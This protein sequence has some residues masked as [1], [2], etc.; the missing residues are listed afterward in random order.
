MSHSKNSGSQLFVTKSDTMK[1]ISTFLFSM[2]LTTMVTGNTPLFHIECPDDVTVDCN[3][4]L[5][6]LS[7]YGNAY[8]YG[9]GDPIPAGDPEVN[10]YL[11]SCNVGSIT[12]TWTESDYSGNTYTC[13]Q[14]ITVTS[15]ADYN[16]LNIEWPHDYQTAEC[17]A[18]LHPDNLAPP[19]DYPTWDQL[20]CAM[21]MQNYK[22]EV[23]EVDEGCVKILRKWTLLDWC[24]Y[25]PN[26]PYSKG[27]WKH[28]QILKIM[29]TE[30]PE[31]ECI[32][33]LTVSAGS[34][35]NSTYV[36]LEKVTAFNNCG[37]NISV[38]NNSPYADE[39]GAD[40]S[41]FY[42][43]G[44]TMIKYTARD[45]CG[46]EAVCK[47]QLTVVDE[48]HPVPI[49]I[50]GISASLG[51]ERDGYYVKIFPELFNKGSYDNCT[52]KHKLKLEVEPD[53]LTCDN[54]DTTPV[55][56]IVTDENGNSD[57]CVTYVYLT[58]NQGKCPPPGT[59]TLAGAV[60]DIKGTVVDEAE[61]GLKTGNSVENVLS[62]SN[63]NYLFD[64]LK[65]NRDYEIVLEADGDPM[66]GWTTLDQ[67]YIHGVL[68]RDIDLD[69]TAG[70]VS[71]DINMDGSITAY[72][73]WLHK[74]YML[75][76]MTLDS[77]W[78]DWRLLNADITA[79]KEFEVNPD[80]FDLSVRNTVRDTLIEK[81]VLLL[82]MGDVDGSAIGQ[83]SGRNADPVMLASETESLSPDEINT[84]RLTLEE[85]V[86]MLGYQYTLSY[87][88]NL[89]KSVNINY[90]D[91]KQLNE[92]DFGFAKEEDG[93]ILCS[94]IGEDVLQFEES[95][96]FL[97]L[98]VEVYE[99]TSLAEAID[100]NSEYLA[101][102]VYDGNYSMRPLLLSLKST[103]A[104]RSANLNVNMKVYPNPVTDNSS[105]H[106][107]LPADIDPD[108]CRIVCIGID[109]KNIYEIK[110]EIQ[111]GEN[112]FKLPPNIQQLLPKGIFILQLI[113]PQ[114][115]SSRRIINN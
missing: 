77:N 40:A 84:I 62:D 76:N 60:T 52:P 99:E 5:W 31:I 42:P 9:Y 46:N 107:E 89:I 82:K 3:E 115:S 13:T 33:D 18:D 98:E 50:H 26:D 113:T 87:N 96:V 68:K 41:G 15:D 37:S 45:A 28:T 86:D 92:S 71:A 103:S 109:G 88:T 53:I 58:D 21:I 73:L 67:L 100:V 64:E 11:N 19:Y 112:Y 55:K 104:T 43:K 59:F 75:G 1:K 91:V 102:E 39:N 23:F 108:E 32:P 111:R 51:I 49:C 54:L 34:D 8:I 83:V 6:D 69:N 56:L 14:T 97:S 70:M 80:V 63:G 106:F 114:G 85:A 78:V 22:D 16:N 29:S 72:D 66:E 94:F 48:K 105:L 38:T 93:V 74:Q 20:S 4:E 61:L 81:N 44:T 36:D 2:L 10:Y 101:A 25:D 17:G 65:L 47:V 30:A 90:N 95:D 57:Y 12:R 24:S 110:E 79:D 35:C 27:K 7:I